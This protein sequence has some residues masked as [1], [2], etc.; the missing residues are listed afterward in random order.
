M[1]KVIF[2]SSFLFVTFLSCQKDNA[3]DPFNYERDTPVW[4]KEKIDSISANNN[5]FGSKVYRYEWRQKYAYHIMIPIS[6]CA[7]CELYE[8]SGN[9][10][11]LNSDMFADFLRNK[12]NEVLVWQ[13]IK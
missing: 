1:F 2:I 4:L 10:M 6:S 3:T 12:K 5:Y 8:Q 7:Y 13:W 11:K 9:K